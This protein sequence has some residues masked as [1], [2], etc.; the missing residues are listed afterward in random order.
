VEASGGP[1]SES[2]DEK[3]KLSWKVDNEDKDELRYRLQYRLVGTT[4]W[5]D[6]LKPQE[7]LTKTNFTWDT[8]DL[9][10][11]RYRVRVVASDELANPPGRVKQHQL[12][13]GVVLVD[14]TAPA[15]KN[16]K[17]TGRTISGIV[18]DGVGPIERIELSVAG[19]GEW[20]PF[21]PRDGVFD[22]QREEFAADVS[23]LVPQGPALVTVRAYDRANNSVL[24]SVSLK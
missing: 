11:G 22:E 5:Y 17:V 4:Q 19:S 8:S 16:L 18:I 7:Q 6:I 13:S 21:F 24:R 10:E 3:V 15:L 14:N 20:Y 1:I 2:P 12:D 9:P 23:S